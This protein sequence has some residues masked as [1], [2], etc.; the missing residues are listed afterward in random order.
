[1]FSSIIEENKFKCDDHID[2]KTFIFNLNTNEYTLKNNNGIAEIK[3]LTK[4]IKL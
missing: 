1:M 2:K 4:I 3:Y